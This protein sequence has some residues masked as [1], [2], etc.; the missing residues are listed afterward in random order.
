VGKKDFLASRVNTGPKPSLGLP[1][2][3][4]FDG[5]AD[6]RSTAQKTKKDGRGTV[7]QKGQND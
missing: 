1:E 3:G 7:Q 5:T 4:R 6:L 2:R